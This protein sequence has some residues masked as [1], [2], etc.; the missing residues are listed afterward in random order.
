MKLDISKIKQRQLKDDQYFRVKYP[1]NQIYLHHTASGPTAKGDIDYWAS[2]VDKIATA[3]VIDRDGT[4]WQAFNSGYYAYHLGVPQSTFKKFKINSSSLE[5]HKH[6]IGIEMDNWGW[7]E[8]KNGK[9]YT[10]TG[11]EI[12]SEDVQVYTPDYLG[13]RYFEKYPPEQIESVRQLLVYLCDA[14]GIPKDYQSDM[15]SVSPRALNGQPG[16]WSHTS[17]RESGKWD[18]HPQEPLIRMLKH[19]NL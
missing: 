12:K 2:N 14:Y 18:A 6:S 10:W 17:V 13:Q 11:A 9:Y 7:L 4:I 3:F 15:W 1:K 16:I 19:L 8:K 5:L